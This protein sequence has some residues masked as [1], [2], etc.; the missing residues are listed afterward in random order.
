MSEAA[1]NEGTKYALTQPVVSTFPNLDKPRAVERNGKPTGDPKYSLNAEFAPDSAD[2]AAIKTACIKA[3]P[4]T[5]GDKLADKAVKNGKDREWSR[6]KV[7]VTARSKYQPILSQ[8]Q[9]GKINEIDGEL[10]PVIKKAFY[11]GVEVLAELNLQ[12]YDGVGSN[13][14]GVTAYLNKVLSLGRGE[15]L[16]KGGANSAEV[17]KDY[18]GGLSDEDPSGGLEDLDDEIPF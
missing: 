2:F 13:P 11:T 10:K 14:D 1:K 18:I 9:G 4:W 12:A 6:G 15:R 17:F 8:L 7:V 5:S 16:V 3:A